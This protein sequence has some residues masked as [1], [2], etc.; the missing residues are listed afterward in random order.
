LFAIVPLLKKDLMRPELGEENSD[1]SPSHFHILFLLEDM[2]MQPMTEI[3]K[4]LQI[5]KSNLTPL[6]QKLIDKGLVERISNEK[7]RRYV[8]ID[9]TIEGI[10]LLK[11]FKDKMADHLRSKLSALKP[12][13]LQRLSTS[14]VDVKDIMLKLI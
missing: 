7:D 8:N 6:I 5:N 10:K 2:G 3:G 13:E 4:H 1:L 14:L 11:S 12:D 9:L